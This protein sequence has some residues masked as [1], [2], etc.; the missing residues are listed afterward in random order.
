MEYTL[1][2]VLAPFTLGILLVTGFLIR[3]NGKGPEAKVLLTYFLF[4]SAYL[5]N[6][7]IELLLPTP[8]ATFTAV[9]AEHLFFLFSQ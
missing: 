8:A 9:K 3:Q 5:L 6:N 2:V 4:V 7:L 1:F